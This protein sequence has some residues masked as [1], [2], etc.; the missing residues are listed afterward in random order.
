MSR[1]ELARRIE[2]LSRDEFWEIALEV[3]HHQAANNL[4]YAEYLDLLH[5]NERE[6]RQRTDI[7]YLP[8]SLFKTHDLRT[9]AWEP[10]RT[11]RSSGTTGTATSRHP[12]RREAW[13]V[14]QAARTFERFYGPLTGRAVLALLPAYLERS[15]SSLVFMADD[16][17][18]RSGQPDSGFY[19]DN[20]PELAGRLRALRERNVPTL[21]LGVSFALLE[22]AERFPQPL[23]DTI[24][25]ETGGMKGRRREMTRDELHGVLSDAFE[26]EHIHSEYGMTELLSQAYAPE[27]GRFLPATTLAVTPRDVTD[28]F[29]PAPLGKTA[30]LNLTDLANLDTVSFIASDDLGRIFE[31]GSFEVLG[32]MDNSDVR[33]CNLLV[34]DL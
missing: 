29:A 4:I 22:L 11:F 24:V 28:P 19:L 30:A 2:G 5:V 7:P 20:L 33:G 23:G 13:Y 15:G 14:D 9:G 31:D 10:S 17:I 21:L 25:M 1:D 26:V 34:G 6:V 12:L 8:I 27:R 18:R 32:R 16:F 3:F